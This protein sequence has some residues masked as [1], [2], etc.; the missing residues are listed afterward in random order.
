ML[1]E[2]DNQKVAV[3]DILYVYIVICMRNSIHI[4]YQTA[5]TCDF[6]TTLNHLQLVSFKWQNMKIYATASVHA[7]SKHSICTIVII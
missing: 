4:F 1:N 3:I 6:N 7:Q 5:M 2:L